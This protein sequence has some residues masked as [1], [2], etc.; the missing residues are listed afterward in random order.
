MASQKQQLQYIY[1][2]ATSK[3]NINYL[4][5]CL[6]ENVVIDGSNINKII[7]A[8]HSFMNHK[9]NFVRVIPETEGQFNKMMEILNNKCI[10]KVAQEYLQKNPDMFKNNQRHTNKLQ[11]EY[12]THGDRN[13]NISQRPHSTQGSSRGGNSRGNGGNND[14]RYDNDFSSRR[15]NDTGFEG[16]SEDL[17]GYAPAFGDTMI[18]NL[19]MVLTQGRSGDG[20]MNSQRNN[21]RGR[22]DGDSN[23]R[24][25]DQLNTPLHSQQ[26]YNEKKNNG[27][28]S[29]MS[30]NNDGGGN[31]GGGNWNG[32]NGGNNGGNGGGNWN[33]NNGGNGGGNGGG[34]WNGNNGGNG[35]GNWNGNNGNN[36]GN[37]NGASQQNNWS[38]NGNGGGRNNQQMQGNNNNGSGPGIQGNGGELS[39]VGG[40][41]DSFSSFEPDQSAMNNNAN[42]DPYKAYLGNPVNNGGGMQNQNQNNNWNNNMS[43]GGNMNN[44]NG[45]NWNDGMNNNGGNWNNGGG[46][47]GGDFNNSKQMTQKEAEIQQNM[48]RMMSERDAMD[49]EMRGQQQNNW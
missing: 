10:E 29:W 27:M 18:T 28:P 17:G 47:M 21:S 14:N 49:N 34:N 33:G 13:N 46:G 44:N 43:N 39:G 4:L 1:N 9:M 22:N 7:G 30:G 42:V 32:N 40:G 20:S 12:E 2:K 16:V 3:D 15:P 6:N 19:P 41:D 25:M 8:I 35:G 38:N 11:R 45:G 37:N 31:N 26:Y 36:G 5:K 23:S 24:Y 48:S